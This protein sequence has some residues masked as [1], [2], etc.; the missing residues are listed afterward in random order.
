MSRQN[1]VNPGMYTQRGRLTQD[2]A[3]RELKRQREVGSEH[4]WQP[5]KKDYFPRL[6][7]NK[8]D[9]ALGAETSGDNESEEGAEAKAATP[10]KPTRNTRAQSS[11]ASRSKAAK[12][13]AV[14]AKT[15]KSAKT[16]KP[17]RKRAAT[18]TVRKAVLARNVGGG[19]PQPRKPATRRKS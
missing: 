16:A 11:T 18:K 5:S 4:T 1:K 3:A 8:N 2:D 6:S 7:S 9:A 15:V 12:K 17:A 10:A 19:G 13:T 14:N